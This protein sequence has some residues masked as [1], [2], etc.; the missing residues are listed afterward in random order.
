MKQ[1]NETLKSK[2][3]TSPESIK[4]LL[5]KF[6]TLKV[7]KE[8]IEKRIQRNIDSIT[9]AQVVQF[10]KIYNSLKDGLSIIED[11]F[12]IS[13]KPQNANTEKFEEVDKTKPEPQAETPA[14]KESKKAVK[15]EAETTTEKANELFNGEQKPSFAD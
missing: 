1:C 14:K 2:A 12:D 9:P 15:K 3:D 13:L 4:K 10:R 8:M 11:W 6:K 5:E 7:S